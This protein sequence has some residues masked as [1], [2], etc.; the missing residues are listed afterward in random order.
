MNTVKFYSKTTKSTAVRKCC[1]NSSNK[2]SYLINKKSFI[3]SS[4][5]MPKV[6]S[7]TSN[8][9]RNLN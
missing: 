2:W 3:R 1:M 7:M 8:F 5:K 4:P 9:K 6:I